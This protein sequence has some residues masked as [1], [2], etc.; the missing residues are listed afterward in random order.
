MTVIPFSS[1]TNI[2]TDGE[3]P[4]PGPGE[5]IER[6]ARQVIDASLSLDH[7]TDADVA[8]AEPIVAA[9]DAIRRDLT[10]A[11][12]RATHDDVAC[13]LAAL[14]AAFPNGRADELFG[15]ILVSDVGAL[16]PSIGALDAACRLLRRT[17]KFLPAIAEVCS[18]IECKESSF[19]LALKMLQRLPDRVVEVKKDRAHRAEVERRWSE[20]RLSKP[21]PQ[22]HD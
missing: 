17:S 8:A 18:M 20:R 2:V 5:L 12:A 4:G 11:M 14:V 13:Q 6:K 16:E 7:P 3:Y 22:N 9:A 19:A 10:R 1:S 21:G 15:K